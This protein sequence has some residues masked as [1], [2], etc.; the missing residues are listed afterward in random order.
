MKN[1]LLVLAILLFSASAF[2]QGETIRGRVFDVNDAAVAN[3]TVKITNL[4]TKQA[5]TTQTDADGNYF[6]DNI[7][8]GK[9]TIS[10]EKE[11]FET[12]KTDTFNVPLTNSNLLNI[13]LKVGGVE[14][15]VN[16]VSRL[17]AQ[18]ATKT[19]LPTSEVPVTVN[20]VS[21]ETLAEQ[22][23]NDLPTALRNVSG[24]NSYTNYGVYEYY[25]LRGFGFGNSTFLIDGVKAEGNRMNTQLANVESVEVLKGPSSVLYGGE[26]IGGT[27][28]IVRKKPSADRTFELGLT[29]GSFGRRAF[30]VGTTGKFGT[31]RLLYRVDTA[32]DDADGWRDA[33]SRRFN[34]TPSIYAQLTN[35]D[36]IVFHFGFNRDRF[37][38]DGGI[39]LLPNGNIPNIPLSRRFSTPQDSAVSQDANLQ[40]NYYHTF[41]DNFE[42]RNTSSF[43]YFN[44][45]YLVAETLA[46]LADARTV[47]REFLYFKHHRRPFLNQAELN[48][49]FN[50]GKVENRLLTG[51]EYQRFYNFTHR[52]AGFSGA[53]V[54]PNIDLYNPVETYSTTN[55][56]PLSRI[57][58]F[59]NQVNAFYFQDHLRFNEKFKVLVGGRYDMFRRWSRNDPVVNGV[60]GVGPRLEREKN[61]FTYRVGA[62]FQPTEMI[63]LYG[64]YATSFRP[65]TSIPADGRNLEP[66]YGDQ[67]EVGSRLVFLQN[68]MNAN[69]ALYN[70]V[71]RNVTYSPSSGVFIQAG[72]QKSSGAEIDIEGNITNGWKVIANYGFTNSFFEDFFS[73]TTNLTGNRPTQAPRHLAN[74]RSVYRFQ[75]GFGF[76]IGGRYMSK[77]FT[78][79]TNRRYLLGGFTTW[80]AAVSYRRDKFDINVNLTNI[81][82]KENYFLTSIN[83]VNIYPGTPRNGQVSLRYRF[84]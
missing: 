75:N 59:R 8:S 65:N 67:I 36:R 7:Q 22:G 56:F 71:K 19:D 4:F 5:K 64:S 21:N 76:S 12:F 77:A 18:T 79:I 38:G 3:A 48:S 78:D 13:S 17:Q 9:F 83:S 60:Q 49:K 10:V 47:R 23:I 27:I 44:D 25:V 16:V 73:G 43:R 24:T 84:K 82:N 1:L 50:L 29:A 69:I 2:A 26:S 63:G 39:P 51:W 81:F 31:E 74:L 45:E 57:D 6:F 55:N 53:S 58:F 80:D 14:A 28:N 40:L 61:A 41:N 35:K 37:D 32:F 70:I 68:R 42:V 11:G 30:S 62:V 54:I 46:V 15:T 66:E 34:I 33:G 20:S 52:R 72:K